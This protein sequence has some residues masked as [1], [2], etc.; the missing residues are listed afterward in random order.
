MPSPQ[1]CQV[2]RWALPPEIG[3]GADAGLERLLAAAPARD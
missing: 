3:L 1:G 2:C